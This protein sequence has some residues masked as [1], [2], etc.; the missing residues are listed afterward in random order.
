VVIGG[1]I[2][3][4][5]GGYNS[6]KALQICCIISILA[7]ASALPIPFVD[8]FMLFKFLIWSLLFLGGFIVPVMTGILLISVNEHER[9]IANSISNLS[10][11]LLGYLPSPFIYGFVCSL[12]GGDQSRYG[13]G[14]LM[15]MSLPA[16]L[17]LYLAYRNIPIAKK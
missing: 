8:N 1:S 7:V 14:L 15:L 4:R 17:F 10:Y 16:S 3:H 5:L 13:I 9:T 6:P 2:I 11:N 12:T